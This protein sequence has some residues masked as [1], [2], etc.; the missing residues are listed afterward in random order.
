MYDLFGV[1]HSLQPDAITVSHALP[2]LPGG[3]TRNHSPSGASGDASGPPPLFHVPL[4]RTLSAMLLLWSRI[5][6]WAIR[7]EGCWPKDGPTTDPLLALLQ[8]SGLVVSIDPQGIR[9]EAGPWPAEP[10]L[11]VHGHSQAMPLATV[12]AL[13]APA[14]AMI[15]GLPSE[16]DREVIDTLASWSGRTWHQ[17]GSSLIFQPMPRGTERG[18]PRF[19]PPDAAWAMAAAMLAFRHPGIHLTSPGELTGS[20]SGFW[21]LYN[22]VL[23]ASAKRPEKRA[24]QQP[25]QQQRQQMAQRPKHAA[26]NASRPTGPSHPAGSNARG[27]ILPNDVQRTKR[28]VKL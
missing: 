25:E 23:T 20:W 10:I 9:A 4:D 8:S 16:Y 6:G 3:P 12:L 7:L 17:E 18:D 13:G 14:T 2:R 28:R 26:T 22:H 27:D 24:D 1:P 11:D 21:T 5:T 15:R 19:E